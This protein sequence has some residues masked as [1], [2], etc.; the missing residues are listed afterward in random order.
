MQVSAPSLIAEVAHPRFRAVVTASL[1]CTYFLGAAVAGW[2]TF[3]VTNWSSEWAWR[4]PVIIQ[5]AGGV[6]VLVWSLC[7]LMVES[8]RWLAYR[9]RQD[10]AHELLAK[11]HANGDRG[12]E[13]VLHEVAEI[14][15]AAELE[16]QASGST[17][18]DFIRTRGNRKR[19]VTA[20][21]FGF[22]TQMSGVCRLSLTRVSR[23]YQFRTASRSCTSLKSSLSWE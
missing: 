12:D 13:L 17:Y 19:V 9:D 23:L 3:G 2:T 16:R 5:C 7:P 4:A 21:F 20:I 11:L 8:P 18:L 6:P 10:Q 1:Q 15:E 14:Q 22:I